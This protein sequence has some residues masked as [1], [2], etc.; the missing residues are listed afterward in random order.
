MR[1]LAN[2]YEES[3]RAVFC[4]AEIDSVAIIPKL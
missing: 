2:R 3:L 4:E 1:I